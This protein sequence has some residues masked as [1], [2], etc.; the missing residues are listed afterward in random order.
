MLDKNEKLPPSD[1]V[2]FLPLATFENIVMKLE[3]AL[4]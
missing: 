1:V 3:T 2:F 4:N